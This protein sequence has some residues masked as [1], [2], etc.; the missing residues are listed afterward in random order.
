MKPHIRYVPGYGWR[1]VLG[2]FWPT[3]AEVSLLNKAWEWCHHRNKLKD[4]NEAR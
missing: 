2:I 4:Q 1:A 3:H